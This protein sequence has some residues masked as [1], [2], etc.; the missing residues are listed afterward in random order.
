MPICDLINYM[1]INH[2]WA[3]INTQSDAISEIYK[4]QLSSPNDNWM[5]RCIRLC[6]KY[7][8]NIR[9]V[10][11]LR[12]VSKSQWKSMAK[13][14]VFNYV[15]RK[16]KL[17][18]L[19]KYKLRTIK[20]LNILGDNYDNWLNT[21]NPLNGLNIIESRYKLRELTHTVPCA[22]NWQS[23]HLVCPLCK[24]CGERDTQLHFVRCSK[25]GQALPGQRLELYFKLN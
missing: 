22:E 2:L 15:Y 23:R 16:F 20:E 12:G 13:S 8:L 10:E 5:K 3:I 25:Y 14:R 17:D 21:L 7:G 9:D 1:K 6:Y 11:H 4:Q 24:H 18:T 19:I